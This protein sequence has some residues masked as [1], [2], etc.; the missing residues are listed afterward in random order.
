[1]SVYSMYAA[2]TSS[3]HLQ[4][5]RVFFFFFALVYVNMP[6]FS[7]ALHFYTAEMLF[8]SLLAGSWIEMVKKSIIIYDIGK[9]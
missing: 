3:G 2:G 8:L 1:M 7:S 5:F 6:F 4:K 9:H